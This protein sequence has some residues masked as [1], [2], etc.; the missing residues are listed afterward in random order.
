MVSTSPSLPI[1]TPEPA[2]C[3][4]SASLLRALAIALTVAPTTAFAAS[5]N[6]WYPASA[7]CIA[8]LSPVERFTAASRGSAPSARMASRQTKGRAAGD[9][10]RDLRVDP[11]RLS[12]PFGPAVNAALPHPVHLDHAPGISLSCT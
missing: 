10:M 11:P 1:S 5:I 2:R 3:A 9:V 6:A 8:T 12:D 7:S 4:P